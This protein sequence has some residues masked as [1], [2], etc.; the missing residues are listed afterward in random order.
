MP[1]AKKKLSLI[2]P[3]PIKN[4]RVVSHLNNLEKIRFMTKFNVLQ[5]MITAALIGL[6][7]CLGGLFGYFVWFLF[8]RAGFLG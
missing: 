8:W 7:L 2:L 6:Y 4:D 1:K 5:E 3:A